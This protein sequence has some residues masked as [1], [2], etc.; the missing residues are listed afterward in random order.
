M[1]LQKFAA[2]FWKSSFRLR[3]S[4]LIFDFFTSDTDFCQNPTWIA[5]SKNKTVYTTTLVAGVW[6]GAVMSWAGAVK[7]GQGHYH[8]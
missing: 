8:P 5:L 2:T 1:E 7:I 3:F 4:S 6:A